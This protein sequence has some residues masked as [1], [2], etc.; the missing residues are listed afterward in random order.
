MLKYQITRSIYIQYHLT[1]SDQFSSGPFATSSTKPPGARSSSS[2]RS[3]RASSERAPTARSRSSCA[4][5]TAAHIPKATKTRRRR[6]RSRACSWRP[7]TWVGEERRLGSQAPEV[8]DFLYCFQ[9]FFLAGEHSKRLYHATSC[10]IYETEEPE[11][12]RAFSVVL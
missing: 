9:V 10:C 5:A 12:C 7:A 8:R 11:V 1:S 6:P 3:K 2:E 4:W